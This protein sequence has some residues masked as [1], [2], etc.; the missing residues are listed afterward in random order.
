MPHARR[1]VRRPVSPPWG[2]CTLTFASASMH[3]SQGWVSAL[4]S[5]VLTH[6]LVGPAIGGADRFGLSPGAVE[7]ALRV[8]VTYE[9]LGWKKKKVKWY[10]GYFCKKR[11]D[12]FTIYNTNLPLGSKP[13]IIPKLLNQATTDSNQGRHP[14]LSNTHAGPH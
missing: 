4:C 10:R 9:K 14:G 12:E 6:G 7:V 1:V 5:L 2:A 3:H 11:K 8:T 13:R